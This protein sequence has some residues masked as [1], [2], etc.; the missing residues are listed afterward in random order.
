MSLALTQTLLTQPLVNTRKDV[1][2][3]DQS[4]TTLPVATGLSIA[5]DSVSLALGDRVIFTALTDTVG[6]TAIWQVAES[7]S[8]LGVPS[9]VFVQ[10][11]DTS[12]TAHST[13]GP[14]SLERDSVHV[15]AGS[16]AGLTML[17]R[18]DAWQ[19]VQVADVSD[20]PSV[21]SFVT[22]V[23]VLS[24][25][26][27]GANLVASKSGNTAGRP[28]TTVVGTQYFDTTI[29]K[30]VFWSGTAWVAATGT[31]A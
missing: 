21:S 20:I 17:F 9:F 16:S 22:N 19:F 29:G 2:V 28:V 14:A 18:E 23:Q 1:K 10:A 4:A 15:L 7:F 8:T 11:T 6:K 3:V 26:S 24:D 13:K 5:A 12:A 25:M 31:S 27:S 30:P